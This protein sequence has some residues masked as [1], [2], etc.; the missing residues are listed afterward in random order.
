MPPIPFQKPT[1]LSDVWNKLADKIRQEKYLSSKDCEMVIE[2]FPNIVESIFTY[3]R[4][5]IGRDGVVNGECVAK[6]LDN[7]GIPT[8]YRSEVASV[9]IMEL[10]GNKNVG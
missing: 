10:T 8:K 2:S 1:E 7:Q 3:R 6:I 4:C 5:L 9:M